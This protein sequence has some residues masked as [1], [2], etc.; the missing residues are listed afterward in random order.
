MLYNFLVLIFFLVDDVWECHSQFS[1]HIRFKA[2][3]PW[4]WGF[5][6]YRVLGIDEVGIRTLQEHAHSGGGRLVDDLC[7]VLDILCF[8]G[9]DKWMI[10]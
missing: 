6:G 3:D 1:N 7:F 8:S 9:G 10:F 4:K 5:W 2:S